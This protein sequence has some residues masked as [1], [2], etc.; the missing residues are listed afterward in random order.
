[1][2]F[3]FVCFTIC[4]KILRSYRSAALLSCVPIVSVISFGH[5]SNWVY[6]INGSN[7]PDSL[8]LSVWLLVAIVVFFLLFSALK[9][10]DNPFFELTAI[11]NTFAIVSVSFSLLPLILSNLPPEFE[12][13]VLENKEHSIGFAQHEWLSSGTQFQLPVDP[14]DFYFIIMD[15]YARED[16]LKSRFGLDNSPFIDW[17]NS[18]GFYV[19]SDSHSNYAWT[20]LSLGATLNAEYLQSLIPESFTVNSP[21]DFRDRNHFIIKLINSRFINN[22]RVHRFFSTLGYRTVSSGSRY[23]AI[24]KQHRVFTEALL[25]PMSEIEKA[26]L[27]NSIL[28]PMFYISHDNEVIK[29]LQVIKYDQVV[30][31]LDSLEFDAYENGPKFVFYHIISPHEPFSFDA[32]GNPVPRHP[33]FDSTQLMTDKQSMTGYRDWFK[34]NYPDNVLGLNYHLK[35]TIQGILDASEGNAV[36]ILQSD[37]GSSL[38]LDPQSVAQS[39]VV[40]RFGI[41]NA[42]FMP[43]KYPRSGLTDTMS[44]VNTFPVIFNNIFNLNLPLRDNHAYYSNGDLEFTDVTDRLKK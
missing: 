11:L 12:P 28:R 32:S 15:A 33:Y 40:E 1:M 29:R 41:L 22:S 4:V 10:S 35:S 7:L 24:R 17:L 19:S 36:I 5:I 2:G 27:S 23:T 31:A 20:H 37:H 9:K 21:E 39:D 42:I 6:S 25:G 43:A 26:L 16:V 8:F 14:P 38:G 13:D 34:K 44:S 3:A 18:K 30:R